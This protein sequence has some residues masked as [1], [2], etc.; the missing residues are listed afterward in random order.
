MLQVVPNS[1]ANSVDQAVGQ[2]TQTCPA[3]RKPAPSL[4][5]GHATASR[6]DCLTPHLASNSQQSVSRLNTAH[7]LR[8]LVS[9]GMWRKDSI[10]KSHRA[11]L[12]QNQC[13]ITNVEGQDAS[14]Q[15]MPLPKLSAVQKL[16]RRLSSGRWR[17]WDGDSII[18]QST[19]KIPRDPTG[20]L[21]LLGNA[22]IGYHQ[23]EQQQTVQQSTVAMTEAVE[24]GRQTIDTDLSMERHI[25][26]RPSATPGIDVGCNNKL[27]DL[28]QQ[29]TGRLTAAQKLRRRLSS[30]R[31]T[32]Q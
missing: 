8:N 32:G 31:W 16:R 4:T 26:S 27:H 30:G 25:R 19:A 22:D 5:E 17:G 20:S 12:M 24:G 10:Y 28:Q 1:T 2:N 15:H 9:F 11:N 18:R 7:K 6:Q 3:A 23:H 29:S 14:S 21:Q 13:S